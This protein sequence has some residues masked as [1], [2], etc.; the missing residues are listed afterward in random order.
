MPSIIEN[1]YSAG[2]CALSPGLKRYSL[3]RSKFDKK[4]FYLQSACRVKPKSLKRKP[5][6]RSVIKEFGTS[7][8][9]C[10]TQ[11]SARLNQP[12]EKSTTKE[13]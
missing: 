4:V 12:L 10:S 6:A 7:R 9:A 1:P 13:F 2:S 3:K 8:T 5:S 11:H